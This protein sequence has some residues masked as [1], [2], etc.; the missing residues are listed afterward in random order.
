MKASEYKEHKNIRK[1]SLRDN[2]TDVEVVL[3]DLGEIATREL[4]K[5]HR[6]QGLNANRKVAKAGG[7][8]AKT[9]RND[10]EKKLGETIISSNNKLNYQYI[11]ENKKLNSKNK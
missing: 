8:V 5:K 4:A 6:P 2:M 11:E 9:A 7:E 10:L 3:T 1:E